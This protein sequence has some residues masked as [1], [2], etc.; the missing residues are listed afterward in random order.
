MKSLIL[1]LTV[2][3]LASCQTNEQRMISEKIVQTQ[4]ETLESKNALQVKRMRDNISALKETISALSRVAEGANEKSTANTQV[5]L[6]LQ[7]KSGQV[8]DKVVNLISSANK[9]VN[10]IKNQNKIIKREIQAY[11]QN[12][13][14]SNRKFDSKLSKIETTYGKDNKS[15][16]AKLT[17]IENGYVDK[18]SYEK[19]IASISAKLKKSSSDNEK[20]IKGVSNKVKVVKLKSSVLES[21]INKIKNDKVNI[22]DFNKSF[23][24]FQKAIK[25]IE[26][27]VNKK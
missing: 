25:G 6:D 2:V 7:K 8:N 15:I 5:V 27:P 4:I 3:F 11:K 19:N 1:I 14:N 12:A 20:L 16:K 23:S 21:E 10:I 26:I 9:N 22:G 17:E 24:S 13:N 18:K